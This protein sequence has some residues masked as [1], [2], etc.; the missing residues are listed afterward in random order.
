MGGFIKYTGV[1]LDV[2]PIGKSACVLELS[3]PTD[4]SPKERSRMN[5]ANVAPPRARWLAIALATVMVCR[6][7]TAST[8]Q[9][10]ITVVDKATGKPVACRMHLVGPKKKPYRPDKVPF[11]HDHFAIPGKIV[12]RLPLGEYAFVIE[13]GP[14]YRDQRGHFTINH[15]ADDAKQIELQRFID[16]AADGWWSGDVDVRRPA[17]DM[18]VLMAADDLHIA[19]V[20]AG[21]ND[22]KCKPA[23]CQK[24]RWCVS[25]VSGTINWR[26]SSTAGRAVNCCCSIYR[27]R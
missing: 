13:R 25:M 15:F 14:E 18:D 21:Q 6:V 4:S 27:R 3:E 20:V 23:S 17:R 9:L 24:R 22:K 8:G 10:Q 11:W 7:A 12:L 16:M 5:R 19:E 1:W 2:R 26:R